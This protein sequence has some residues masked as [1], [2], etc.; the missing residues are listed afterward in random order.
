[1]SEIPS[2]LYA[3]INTLHRAHKRHHIG[4]KRAKSAHTNSHRHI[5]RIP[6]KILLE[7]L[8]NLK[9]N[10][11]VLDLGCG[12]GVVSIYLKL[13]FPNLNLY[14]SDV[15]EWCVTLTKNNAKKLNLDINVIH[16]DSFT[17]I[18]EIFDFIVFNPP[19]SV[20]KD[21]IYSMYQEAY[22]HLNSHGHFYIVIR[23]DKGALSHMKYLSSL[24]QKVE[25]INKEKGYF[26][27][28]AIKE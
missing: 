10:N 4:I 17:N 26:V 19:I 13:K 1:M 12:Y 24:Y 27:I 28:L 15:N 21:K 25:I 7:T 2:E 11:K 22:E 23:K 3:P 9:L 5:V 18:N 16:S 6:T 14:A 20:G 8:S